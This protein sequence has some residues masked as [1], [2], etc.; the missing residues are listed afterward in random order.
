MVIES[1]YDRLYFSDLSDEKQSFKSC[2]GSAVKDVYSPYVDDN[3]SLELRVSG[4]E[5]IYQYIQSFKD[6]V[7]LNLIIAR[8]V[9]G[10]TQALSKYKGF[11]ADVSDLPSSYAGFLDIQAKA[12]DIFSHLSVEDREKFGFDVNKFIASFG[13]VGFFDLFKEY[14]PVVEPIKEVVDNEQK[15]E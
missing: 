12:A 7:D 6:S 11:F 5:N 15:P 9:A 8:F 2:S 13:T 10:D 3:G 14:S 4:K 1:L